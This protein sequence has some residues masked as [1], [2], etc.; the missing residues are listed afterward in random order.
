MHPI[1]SCAECSTCDP[2]PPH[3][4]SPS[5]LPV[6]P[7]AVQGVSSPGHPPAFLSP[8]TCLGNLPQNLPQNLPPS[9]A[10]SDTVS[11]STLSARAVSR[12]DEHSIVPHSPLQP[13]SPAPAPSLVLA[14]LIGVSFC[15]SFNDI[16]IPGETNI[17]E[18]GG[19][20]MPLN[21]AVQVSP[22]RLRISIPNMLGWWR[23]CTR[24]PAASK[25]R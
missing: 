10:L 16:L 7:A 12:P 14:C 15:D 11:C 1:Y 21:S 19:L 25:G 2:T 18:F 17:H 8:M 9:S 3:A 24:S 4:A 13:A 22:S 6:H 5:H 20:Q 23:S